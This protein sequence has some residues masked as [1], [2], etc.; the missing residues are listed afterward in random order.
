[1][2]QII[3]NIEIDGDLYD[4]RYFFDAD[5]SV[6]GID[7]YRSDDGAPIGAMLEKRFPDE[8]DEDDMDYIRKEL[9]DWLDNNI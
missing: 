9:K 3:K 1:M 8:D 2:S 4:I 7:I 6:D 5:E